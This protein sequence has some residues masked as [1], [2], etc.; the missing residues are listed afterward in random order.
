MDKKGRD[1]YELAEANYKSLYL[2][3]LER[4]LLRV[5]FDEILKGPLTVYKIRTERDLLPDR[6]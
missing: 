3:L 1:Y 5:S 4:R 2:N 6:L